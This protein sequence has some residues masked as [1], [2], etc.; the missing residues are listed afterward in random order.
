MKNIQKKQMKF[1]V[2]WGGIQNLGGKFPPSKCPE[3]NTMA[4]T[5]HIVHGHIAI[6][7]KPSPPAFF[8]FFFVYKNFAVRARVQE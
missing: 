8:C 5:G 6:I 3:K 7:T 2:V 4:N 1:V